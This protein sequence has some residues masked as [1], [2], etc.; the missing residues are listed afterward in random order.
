M[1]SKK[2]KYY[3]SRVKKAKLD[4]ND[5]Y[6]RLKNLYFLYRDRDY[7]K[8]KLGISKQHIP[9]DAV[10]K[11]M[12]ETG[13]YIFPIEDWPST[14]IEEE[15]IFDTIEFLFDHISKPGEYGPISNETGFIYNDY[16]DY[17]E[18]KGKIEFI[19]S[20]NK[21]LEDYDSGF[22]LSDDGNIKTLG[23]E[24]LKH[25]F[26]I[27]I[28]HFDPVNVDRKVINAIHMWRNRKA[29]IEDRK[30]A[31]IE[32]ADVFEWLK[33]SGKLENIFSKKDE[34]AIF[35]IAN[36][37]HIRHHDPR[38]IQ[39]YDKNI[40]YSWIFH[41]YLATYHAIIRLIIKG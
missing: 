18:K 4:I 20:V 32:L 35:E 12:L 37:F 30:Q 16:L 15:D 25:L 33:K 8:E 29:N 7:F 22:E 17:N 9:E 40:W 34:F 38:Q 36:K 13:K 28:P 1:N 27:D 23:E 10:Y 6:F 5:L 31:I 3:S 41:F 21:F 39:N 19:D 2:R 24:G 11:V 26:D 14:G